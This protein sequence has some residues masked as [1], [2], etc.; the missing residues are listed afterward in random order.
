MF[1]TA[2]DALSDKGKA[3]H[4]GD[5]LLALAGQDRIVGMLRGGPGRG[6]G[7]TGTAAGTKEIQFVFGH[8][9]RYLPVIEWGRR[10]DM[11]SEWQCIAFFMY[12]RASI[13]N[14]ETENTRDKISFV[15]FHCNIAQ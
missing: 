12:T 10:E 6:T 11:N 4:E 7:A 5:N 9:D 8:N 15:P 13:K 2:L 3:L 14:K 1:G